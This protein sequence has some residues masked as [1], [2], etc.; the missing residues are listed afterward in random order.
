MLITF[1]DYVILVLYKN[2]QKARINSKGLTVTFTPPRFSVKK[3]V[4]ISLCSCSL[5]LQLTLFF[6]FAAMVST[7]PPQPKVIIITT[8]VHLNC[9][10]MKI[11]FDRIL[12]CFRRLHIVKKVVKIIEFER[13]NGGTRLFTLSRPWSVPE[14]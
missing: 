8:I 7:S 14:F 9:S 2:N 4:T 11:Q 1:L 6:V 10:M 5:I 12:I 13:Q 3:S